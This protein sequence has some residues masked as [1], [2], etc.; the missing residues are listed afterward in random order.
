MI[1]ADFERKGGR[2]A[3]EAV[4]ESRR[5][6]ADLKIKFIG[7]RPPRDV[8][9]LPFVEWCGW[10]NLSKAEDRRQFN[11]IISSAG[12]QVLFSRADLTPLAI[13]E[14]ASYS[15]G[16]IAT[17][18]GGIPEMIRDGQT[19]WLVPPTATAKEIGTALARLFRNPEQLASVGRAAQKFCRENWSWCAVA[20]VGELLL[21]GQNIADRCHVA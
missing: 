20:D 13:P 12:A 11:H 15:K 8:M 1:A 3:V 19:G 4:T 17:S 16:T 14:A 9:N 2:L 5:E 10:L 6:G 21:S 18:V 7:A